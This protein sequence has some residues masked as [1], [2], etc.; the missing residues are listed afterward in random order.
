MTSSDRHR[1]VF[2]DRATVDAN[3]R[4]PAFP[5]QWIEH[6]QTREPDIADRLAGATIAITNKV[7]L[8]GDTIERLPEL[9]FIAVAATG[10]DVVDLERCRAQG[11]AVSNIRHYAK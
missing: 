3:F 10:V 1:I 8:S 9:R 5:H 11:V 4:S 6:Q 7:P 2:L